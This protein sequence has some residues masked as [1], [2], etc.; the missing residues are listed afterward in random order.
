MRISIIIPVWN[1]LENMKDV[2]HC[3]SVQEVDKD[4]FELILVDHQSSDGFGQWVLSQ[5]LPF[6][7]KYLYIGYRDAWNAAIPRNL[8][9][10]ISDPKSDFLYFV[11]SDILLPPNRLQC[12]LNDLNEN[13]DSNR[14][15]IGP[16]HFMTS[17]VNVQNPDWHKN[18]IENYAQDIRFKDFLEHPVE[19]QRQGLNMAL[20]C[21]GGNICMSRQIFFKAGGYDENCLNGTEDGDF[22]LTLWETGATVAMDINLL[23][24]HQ[25]H[26]VEEVRKSTPWESVHYIDQKHNIDVIKETATTYR[27]WGIDWKIPEPGDGT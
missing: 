3:L 12:L 9:A 7:L 17:K 6:K 25:P 21:F 5:Q 2:L 22:G 19:E 15:I 11:D 16:Y 23:A 26:P 27:N 14:I 4:N 24:W 20:A 18:G 8:G 10:K 1:R 13:P